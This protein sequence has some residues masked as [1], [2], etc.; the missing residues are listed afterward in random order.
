MREVKEI[1]VKLAY[2]Q[3]LKSLVESDKLSASARE[4]Y[5]T[6]LKKLSDSIDR[7]LDI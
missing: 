1:E 4:V 6:K 7:D 2:L 3:S 5:A